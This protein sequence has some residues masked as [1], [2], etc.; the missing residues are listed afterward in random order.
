M[1]VNSKITQTDLT[2]PL[3]LF[4]L[5]REDMYYSYVYLFLL[6]PTKPPNK[7]YPLTSLHVNS[8]SKKNKQTLTPCLLPWM[9][10]SRGR[11]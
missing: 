11:M 2:F 9:Y 10:C 3:H 1:R 4:I 8:T 6:L 5:Q 7:K